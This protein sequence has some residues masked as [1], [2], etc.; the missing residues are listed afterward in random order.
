MI[1]KEDDLKNLVWGSALLGSGGG[2][3]IQAGMDFV[4]YIVSKTGGIEN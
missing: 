2:G 3:S 4:A 1:L